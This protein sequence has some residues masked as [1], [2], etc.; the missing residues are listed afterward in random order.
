MIGI[1]TLLHGRPLVH[2][3]AWLHLHK[4]L[5]HHRAPLMLGVARMVV[6]S[7]GNAHGRYRWGSRVHLEG[8]GRTMGRTVWRLEGGS[9]AP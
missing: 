5:L 1:R 6:G 3:L 8:R 2:R 9:W 7:I 4:P